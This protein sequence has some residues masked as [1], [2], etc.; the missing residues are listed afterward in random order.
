M[1]VLGIIGFGKNP[2]ACLLQ[3]GKLISLVEEERFTRLKSSHGMFP[4]ELSVTVYPARLETGGHRPGPRSVGLHKIPLASCSFSSF[5]IPQDLG[6]NTQSPCRRFA[7]F[8]YIDSVKLLGEWHP[9]VVREK[10]HSGTASRGGI[11]GK[12]PKI[13]FVTYHLSHAY[14]TYFCS[15]FKRAGVLT[16]DGSGEDVCTQLAVAED[17]NIFLV[18]SFPIPHSLGWFY[19]AITQY[20]GFVPYRDEGKV[21]GLGRSWGR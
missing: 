14:S 15:G 16:I 19:A 7:L 11:S 1:N 6:A 2:G 4:R 5:R 20:L 12:F 8:F 17:G 3:D 9:S 13:R 21:H 18:E 10:I